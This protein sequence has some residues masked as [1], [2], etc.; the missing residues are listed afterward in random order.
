MQHPT[1]DCIHRHIKNKKECRCLG[2]PDHIF[3]GCDPFH[4]TLAQFRTLFLI[5]SLITIIQMTEV[6]R[7][8]FIQLTA[9]VASPSS[10][11]LQP[12]YECIDVGAATFAS[13]NTCSRWVHYVNI[14]FTFTRVGKGAEDSSTWNFEGGCHGGSAGD[15]G[16]GGTKDGAGDDILVVYVY[17]TT[18]CI[19]CR[20]STHTHAGL[21]L[22]WRSWLHHAWLHSSKGTRSW[23]AWLLHHHTRSWLHHHSRLLLSHGRSCSSSSSWGLHHHCR[24]SMSLSWLHKCF[25]LLRMIKWGSLSWRRRSHA[26]TH[27]LLLPHHWLPHWLTGRWWP[28]IEL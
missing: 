25:R 11:I 8:R 7:G 27:W 4:D 10:S 22:T 9:D 1:P 19:M 20:C 3:T 23:W 18:G 15:H 12:G 16:R 14:T 13:D 26:T 17:G 28:S 24:G 21:A 6:S 5:P 2:S